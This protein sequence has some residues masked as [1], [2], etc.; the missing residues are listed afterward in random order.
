MKNNESFFSGFIFTKF[1][2][3]KILALMVFVFTFSFISFAAGENWEFGYSYR[4]QITFTSDINKIPSSQTNFPVLINITDTDLKTVT[5]GGHVQNDNGWDIKFTASDGSTDLSYEIEKYDPATGELVAWVKIPTL[6][7]G[8]I[9]YMYYG[10]VSVNTDPSSP[11]TWEANYKMVQH[12]QETSGTHYDSTSNALDA[13]PS[14][15]VNQDTSGKIDGADEFD[16]VDDYVS[17]SSSV[18]LSPPL[19]ISAW[20]YYGGQSNINTI[21]SNGNAEASSAG[22]R[23]FIN[24][25]N[26]SDGKLIIEAGDGT[27]GSSIASDI[28]TIAAGQWYFVTAVIDG[29]NSALYL[30]GNLIGT[31]SLIDCTNDSPIYIGRMADAFLFQGTIDEVRISNIGRS[32]DWIKIEYENQNDPS[33]FYSVSSEEPGHAELSITKADNPDPVIAGN[34]LT[35]TV[36]VTNNGP[37]DAYNVVVTDTVPSQLQNVEYST[38]GNTWTAWSGSANL[39][40]IASGSSSQILIRGTVNS[41]TSDGIVLDNSAS[42]TT[43]T[44]ELD[45]SDNSATASTT[46]NTS[47][48]LSITKTDNPDP[49]TAGNTLTYTITVTNN[50]PSDAQNVVVTDNVPSELENVEYSTDGNTWTAWSGSANLETI[51]S[52]SSSQILIRG[53]VNSSTA[54]GTTINNTASVTTDTTDPDTTNNSVTADT[55]VTTSANLSI[56]KS[57]A[58]SV[59]AGSLLSYVITVTNNGPSDSQNVVVTDNV[60][61]ELENVEYSTDGNTWT[62]WT[63]SANLGTIASGSNAQILIRGTVKSNTADG[64]VLHNTASVLSDT[65]D[66]DSSDNTSND[67]S[68]TITTNADLSITK[69]VDKANEYPRGELLYTITVT[70]NGPS[71]AENVTINDTLPAELANALYSSD[72]GATWNIWGGQLNIGTIPNGESRTIQ[73]KATINDDVSEGTAIDN[74]ATVTSNTNDSDTSNN[75][76]GVAETIVQCTHYTIHVEVANGEGSGD[77]TVCSPYGCYMVEFSGNPNTHISELYINGRSTNFSRN[78]T[79]YTFCNIHGDQEIKVVY[80]E[81]T[82]PVITNFVATPSI[83]VKPLTVHF[84][85]EGYDPDGGS[86]LKYYWDF[87]GD[88]N[89]DVV[90]DVP[91]IDHVYPNQGEYSAQ[92][93]I[94]DDEGQLS[95]PM[96]ALI[97]VGRRNP[98]SI[99]L[100]SIVNLINANNQ[101]GYLDIIN[102]NETAAHFSIESSENSQG[103]ASEEYTLS[104]NGKMT[105]DITSLSANAKVVSDQELLFYVELK[106]DGKLCSDYIGNNIGDNLYVSHVAEETD[107][108]NTYL[109]IS[110]PML[111]SVYYNDNLLTTN[112]NDVFELSQFHNKATD[113]AED[114]TDWWGYIQGRTIDPFSMPAKISGLVLYERLNGDISMVELY[115]KP[116]YTGYIAHIPTETDMFWY[117]YVITNV[118]EEDGHYVL[119]FYSENGELLGQEQLTIPAGQKKKGLLENDYAQ[120]YGNV[121]WI[122]IEGDSPFI[123]ESVYGAYVNGEEGGGICGLSL[124]TEGNYKLIFPDSVEEGYWTGLSLVN[125]EQEEATVQIK[126]INGDGEEAQSKIIH[127]P[128]LSQAKVVLDNEFKEASKVAGNYVIVESNKKLIGVEIKGDKHNN[129]LCG[130]VGVSK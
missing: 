60:P 110:N 91:Q 129:V 11:D 24:S 111:N 51:A 104:A 119:T 20:I 62:A 87:D 63:G 64:T 1:L 42:V 55:A 98:I 117:G 52:G 68:T 19:T 61:S 15:G 107:L 59:D 28:D 120:Y 81:E 29:S 43:D 37:S 46:V 12:L 89:T 49:V 69:S 76:S 82:N 25:W 17:T 48:D 54:E 3:I 78:Q 109:I 79:T 70:N 113:K 27:N 84:T 121:A 72:N 124:A 90:T 65:S 80:V 5:N 74:F 77:Y 4:K 56:T 73:I 128:A 39:G 2:K 96:S 106:G 100:S 26:T 71:Y 93:T 94:K 8:T 86:I 92:L 22:F 95:E 97:H 33:S 18:V 53:T 47:S 130:V 85:A 40:I 9:I 13:T 21:V 50:G 30:N 75:T 83:G 108:W 88:G 127:I 41:S 122:K 57:G 45:T 114:L 126:L 105:F 31:G 23:L 112:E 32:G 67:V 6:S 118:G 103:S 7:T 102:P 44:D 34:T 10:S 123:G 36:T 14:G 116:V 58:S 66:P 125:T 99:D 101:T 35:Y 16:G 115:E 38:D